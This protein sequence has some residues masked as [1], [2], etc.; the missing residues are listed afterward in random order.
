METLVPYA[1]WAVV[2]LVALGIIAIVIFG[3]RGLTYGKADPLSIAI[4]AI[5]GVVLVLLGFVLGDW[6]EAGIW[7]VV[8]MI[9]VA[10]LALLLSGTRGLFSS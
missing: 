3:L 6:A 9:G 2:I 5:P 7:T 10:S 1:I 8:I 4:V